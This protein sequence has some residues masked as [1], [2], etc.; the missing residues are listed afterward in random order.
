MIRNSENTKQV[1]KIHEN[2]MID[3]EKEPVRKAE[4][5]RVEA[6]RPAPSTN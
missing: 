1:K 3:V 5:A 2:V 6:F 4:S